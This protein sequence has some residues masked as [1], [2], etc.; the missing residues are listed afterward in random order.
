MSVEL[1][2]I[3]VANSEVNMEALQSLIEQTALISDI[4]QTI[5]YIASQTNLLALNAAIEAAR[6]G[7]HGRGFAVVADEVRRLAVNSDEAI[8]KVNE[9][10]KNISEGVVKVS[11]ITENSQKMVEETQSKISKVMDSFGTSLLQ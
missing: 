1:G 2:D 7:D 5:K 6:A 8:K 4:S 10:V 3:V 11:E 9:N